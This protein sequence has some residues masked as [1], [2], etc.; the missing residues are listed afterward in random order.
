[1]SNAKMPDLTQCLQR[2]LTLF[3]GRSHVH[4]VSQV[5]CPLVIC[6]V[7]RTFRSISS[8]HCHILSPTL[9]VHSFG[10]LSGDA[11][12]SSKRPRFRWSTDHVHR[13]IFGYTAPEALNK[14]R[15]GKPVDLWSIGYSTL[16]LRAGSPWSKYSLHPLVAHDLRT[17]DRDQHLRPA[18]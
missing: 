5:R 16:T 6:T 17:S 12:H 18:Q 10:S 8:T 3:V 1:M 9:A 15:H 2:D 4:W 11:A 14:N 13:N 7:R